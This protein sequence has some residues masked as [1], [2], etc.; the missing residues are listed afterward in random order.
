VSPDK[1]ALQTDPDRD[2]VPNAAI[3]I[4]YTNYRG[5]RG[6]RRIIPD[7]I[8]FG[9]NEWHPELQWLLLAWDIEKQ[10][11]RLFAVRDIHSWK[12]EERSDDGDQQGTGEA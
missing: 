6:L 3:T 4:D 1:P 11:D 12:I 8:S 7:Q 10:A 5:E 9:S 2:A